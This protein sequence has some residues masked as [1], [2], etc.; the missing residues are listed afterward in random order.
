MLF[1]GADLLLAA[2]LENMKVIYGKPVDGYAVFI[3]HVHVDQHQRAGLVEG[4]R[5]MQAR[6]HWLLNMR[7]SRSQR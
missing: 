2:S 6:R 3:C 5:L 4:D 1:E 7:L